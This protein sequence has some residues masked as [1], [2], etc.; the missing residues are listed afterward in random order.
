M[1]TVI[2]S[3]KEF[4]PLQLAW[5]DFVARVGTNWHLFSHVVQSFLIRHESH[6]E[7]PAVLVKVVDGNVAGVCAFQ[8]RRRYGFRFARFLLPTY[9]SPDFV[10]KPEY[11]Q[12]FVEESL[13]FLLK[14]MRCQVVTLTLPGSSP[15]AA[16]LDHY[17]RSKNL[18]VT[19]TEADKHSIV[20]VEG[21]WAD[22]ERRRGANFRYHLN[23]IEGKLTRLGGWRV[24]QAKANSS[25][26]VKKITSVE[27]HSWKH[28]GMKNQPLTL[29]DL[30]RSLL[31]YTTFSDSPSLA[32]FAPDVWFLELEGTPISY[33]IGVEINGVAYL[34][35]TSYDN[36]YRDLSPGDYVL[37]AAIK[38][39]FDSKRTLRIDLMSYLP[40]QKRWTSLFESRD[41]FRISRGGLYFGLES[42]YKRLPMV[43]RFGQFD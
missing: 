5:D 31:H 33:V 3:A 8:T 38:S 17:C 9:F 37:N 20:L 1:L 18:R 41:S 7:I 34:A 21:E 36:R 26:S 12:S 16:I 25:D 4:E 14:R 10:V 2:T 35:K 6:G 28:Q 11:R 23:R 13:Q 39:L 27:T 19:V 30:D 32:R 15:Q 40:F 29:G 22:F 42:L 24:V 43:N